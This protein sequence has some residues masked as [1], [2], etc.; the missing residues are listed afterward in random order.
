MPTFSALNTKLPSKCPGI[1]TAIFETDTRSL[2]KENHFSP[3]H[4]AKPVTGCTPDK[5]YAQLIYQVWLEIN[6]L[7]PFNIT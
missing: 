3:G 1:P 2:L 7:L 6:I 4:K 5:V